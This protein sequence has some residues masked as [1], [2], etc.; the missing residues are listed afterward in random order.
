MGLFDSIGQVLGIG[1]QPDYYKPAIQSEDMARLIAEGAIPVANPQASQLAAARE[2][3]IKT[4]MARAKEAGLDPRAIQVA[5]QQINDHYMQHVELATSAARSSVSDLLMGK[6]QTQSQQAQA[7]AAYNQ[8]N[9]DMWRGFMGMGIGALAGGAGG[10][11]AGRAAGGGTGVGG[12]FVAPGQTEA[13]DY[14]GGMGT[15]PTAPSMLPSM[16]PNGFGASSPLA[17]T[18]LM[19]G[20][21]S[22]PWWG[23][24]QPTPQTAPIQPFPRL[25]GGW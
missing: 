13:A 14:P 10:A 15:A 17:P 18:P 12:P 7:K 24:G 21:M 19:T 4:T 16:M 25:T 22:N 5:M 9:I 1:G 20:A 11:A 2:T 3:A 23:A 8:S 6:A